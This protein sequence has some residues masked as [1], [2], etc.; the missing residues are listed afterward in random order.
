MV[1]DYISS[2][3]TG[4]VFEH[5]REPD[6]VIKVMK[7]FP[8]VGKTILDAFQYDEYLLSRFPDR[9]NAAHRD[10][11]HEFS[12]SMLWRP[13][14][15]KMMM[16]M[17]EETMSYRKGGTSVPT[18]LPKIYD[19][20]LLEIP[21]QD[22]KSMFENIES[23]TQDGADAFQE[24]FLNMRGPGH[25]NSYICVM[26]KLRVPERYGRSHLRPRVEVFKEVANFLW[27]DLGMVTRDTECRNL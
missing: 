24:N 12:T 5:N 17:F 9:Y 22:A 21:L 20:A 8:R 7:A 16:Y 13:M 6:K 18:G 15:A 23:S 4:W 26:E 10:Y 11:D 1:G 25:R 27:N 19:T 2:G 14:S 3:A